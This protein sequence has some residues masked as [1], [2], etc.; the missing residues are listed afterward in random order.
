M[1]RLLRA[2]TAQSIIEEMPPDA[3]QNATTAVG[4]EHHTKQEYAQRV[5]DIGTAIYNACSNDVSPHIE[6]PADMWRIRHKRL[7]TAESPTD[8]QAL[9]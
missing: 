7:D 6:N 4:Q 8:R 9:H 5:E 3:P 2:S 1:R